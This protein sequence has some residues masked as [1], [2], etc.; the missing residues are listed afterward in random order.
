MEEYEDLYS[1]EGIKKIKAYK[2]TLLINELQNLRN[3]FW[4]K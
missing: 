3:E 1:G 2:T 4:C